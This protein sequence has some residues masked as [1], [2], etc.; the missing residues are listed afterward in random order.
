MWIRQEGDGTVLVCRVRPNAG[1]DSIEGVREDHVSVHLSAPAVE[2]KANKALVAFLA[3]RLHIAKSKIS[4]K[5]GEKART[6]VL[7]ISGMAPEEVARLL[8]L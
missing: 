4:V 2:G 3:K 8:G 1:R 7:F 6:K 5:I